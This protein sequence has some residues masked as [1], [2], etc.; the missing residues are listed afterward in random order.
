MKAGEAWSPRL[1]TQLCYELKTFLLAGHETSAAMLTLTL[2]ELIHN[3]DLRQRVVA[4][5]NAVLGDGHGKVS[6][7][8]SIL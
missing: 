5:A 8:V 3:T 4:E 6:L 7:L 1:Q 2:I